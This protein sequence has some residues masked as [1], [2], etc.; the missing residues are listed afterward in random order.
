MVPGETVVASV[1]REVREGIGLTITDVIPAGY[2]QWYNP[3]RQSQYF[4][5]LFKLHG[6]L[7][8]DFQDGV[9]ESLCFDFGGSAPI[10]GERVSG[11]L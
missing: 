2:I 7:Y 1:I 4:V 11:I 8:K 6:I 5:F 10:C 9:F 3:D